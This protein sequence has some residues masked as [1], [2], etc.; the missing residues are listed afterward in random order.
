MQIKSIRQNAGITQKSLAE[1]MGVSQGIVSA[2]EHE[3]SLP[4]T[5]DLPLLAQVLECSIDDLYIHEDRKEFGGDIY[6]S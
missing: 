1:S 3:T 6:D 2:W 5:R 4:R